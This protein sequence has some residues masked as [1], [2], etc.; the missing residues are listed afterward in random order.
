MI[1]RYSRPAMASIWSD[2]SRLRAMLRV[3]EALLA[4]LA[5]E[6]R[7][8]AAELKALKRLGEKSLL[9]ASRRREAASAHEV[10]GLLAAVAGEL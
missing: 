7:I 1:E 8:P 3:E 6:K 4:A 9:D 5:A 10:I 2:E